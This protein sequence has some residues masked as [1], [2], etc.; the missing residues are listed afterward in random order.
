M[1]DSRKIDE[2]M[3]ESLQDDSESVY[4][5]N[6]GH[7]TQDG[8]RRTECLYCTGPIKRPRLAKDFCS[9]KCRWKWN[10]NQKKK[11]MERTFRKIVGFMKEEGL[12]YLLK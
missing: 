8:L 3:P 11:M 9:D 10:N 7:G 12:D 4:T 6:A 5:E 1:T 2:T